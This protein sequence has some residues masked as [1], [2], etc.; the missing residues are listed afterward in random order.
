L[1][2]GT[3]VEA[4][5]FSDVYFTPGVFDRVRA[6]AKAMAAIERSIKEIPG[7]GAV[8]RADQLSISS[9]DPVVR[10]AALSYMSGRSGDL[11][12]VPSE[13]WYFSVRN[14]GFATTHGTLHEYDTHVPLIFFGGGITAA[15][16]A[17]PVTPADIAPTLGHL[18]G[19]HVVQGGGSRPVGGASLDRRHN[20]ATSQEDCRDR[21]R[22]RRRDPR[23]RAHHRAATHRRHHA[24]AAD[25]RG[26]TPRNRSRPS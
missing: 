6:N 3:Y 23:H 17:T 18:A 14:A 2:K 11:M 15:H 25:L 9:T 19:R 7:V 10:S 22:V 12:I 8:L 20:H 1:K 16:V 4:V 13:Y 26:R 5:N 21:P 24:T